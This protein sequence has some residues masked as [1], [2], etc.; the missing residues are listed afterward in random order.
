[1]IHK[2]YDIAASRL[3]SEHLCSRRNANRSTLNWNQCYLGFFSLLCYLHIVQIWQSSLSFRMKCVI[4]W[5]LNSAVFTGILIDANVF[6]LTHSIGLF[7]YCK[8]FFSWFSPKLNARQN[9]FFS[10]FESKMHSNIWFQKVNALEKIP[11]SFR[12]LV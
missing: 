1:M 5:S 12:F 2:P 10:W 8:G 6:F 3:C 4:Y 9:S 11:C 7:F